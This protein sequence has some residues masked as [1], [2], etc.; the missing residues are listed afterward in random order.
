MT[1]RTDVTIDWRSSPRLITVAAP[2]TEITIQDIV[3]TCRAFED[4]LVG[5][6][7]P[8][9][10]DAAGKEFL[11][12]TTYVGVTAT[13]QNC[14]LAFEARSGPDWVL[15]TIAGG[16]LV[17]VDV[18]GL[19]ID[20]RSPTAFV[21]VDRTASASATLQE[22]SALQY[23]SFNGGITLDVDSPYSGTEYPIGTPQQPVNNIDDAYAIAESRGFPVI[24]IL[25]DLS[26]NAA[27]PPLT[28]YTFIGQ[29]MDR[30][31]IDIDPLAVVTDCAY[32]D[33]TVTGTLDGNSRLVSC[34]ID[35]LIYVKGFI[36]QC[37][38]AP[39][40]ITLA[41]SEEAHFLDCWSG[42]PG[43]D[44]PTINL[45]GSG[46]SLALRNYNGGIKL[47]NKSGIDPVSIDLNSGQIILD[48]TITNG[49]I[50][51]RGIG[52]LTNNSVGA[53]VISEDLINSENIARS[54]WEAV[55]IDTVNG[56]AG[57]AYPIGTHSH[58]SNNLTD[59]LAIC[60]ANKQDTIWLHSDLTIGAGNDVS[61]MSISTHG[62]MG[63]DVIL[64]AGCIVDNAVFR[65]VN[66]QGVISNGDT[67]LIE[68]CSVLNLENFTGLM[69]GVALGQGS[70][71]SIGTWAEIYNCRAGGEPGNEP[72]ISIGDAQ[73]S[74]QQYRGNLKLTNKTGDNRTVVS[75][76]PANV[77]IDSTCVAGRIQ[78]LGIGNLEADN[79][80]PGCQVDLD[81]VISNEF[82]AD[83]VWE[84]TEA[85]TALLQL[86]DIQT[87]TTFTKDIEGGGWRIVN[88]QMIFYKDDNVT[89][90]ARFDLTYDG[91]GNP[92]RRVRV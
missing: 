6:L 55:V 60:T 75:G 40:T 31:I 1:I 3:D 85:I 54:T 84:H 58:P 59:A 77:I 38:L 62:I 49:E 29:G 43:T 21:T 41:G 68:S 63:T 80:G 9:L 88:G 34:L 8:Y 89:E 33:A 44:I 53:D 51:C 26:I 70:Q 19:V 2:S 45:G 50:V 87:G 32:Q 13:L 78:G 20:P 15:C 82:I 92:I 65:Y 52:K 61:K 69:Q 48:S 79:S 67:L 23:S 35:D 74:I 86:D 22:Q 10:I 72:E 24:F 57:T 64:E 27:V 4:S 7:Y 71:M 28:D 42:V 37:V 73:L 5:D 16:N 47:T 12:G 76:L 18:D 91:D 11:G 25:G 56:T 14:T 83:H 46:Q 30:T 66:V 17:A 81:A 39:G 36:E 90:I